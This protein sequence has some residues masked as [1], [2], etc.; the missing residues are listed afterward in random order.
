MDKYVNESINNWHHSPKLIKKASSHYI[1]SR[2]TVQ[3]T[4]LP[5]VT[6]LLRVTQPFSGS[7]ILALKK[8]MPQ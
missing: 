8:N 2:W 1:A 6:P 7:T 3:K 5:T 4:P